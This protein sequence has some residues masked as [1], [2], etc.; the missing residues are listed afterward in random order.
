MRVQASSASMGG[1][2]QN[3]IFRYKPR[4]PAATVLYQ[5][6]QEH[7]ATFLALLDQ[8]SSVKN[9]PGYVRDEFMAFLRCGILAHGFVRYRCRACHKDLLLAFSCK[10]R[11]FCPSCLARRMAET[12]ARLVT[13]ILPKQPYRQWVL[14]LPIPL[15]YWCASSPK[16][17]EFVCQAASAAIGAYYQA[18][19]LACG[20]LAEHTHPGL[21]VFVQR[22]GSALNLNVHLH[23][24]ALDGVYVATTKHAPPR[25]ISV[26]APSHKDLQKT[27][28]GLV[29]TV[30]TQLCAWGY[31]VRD[32]DQQFLLTG[33]D[34]LFA[35]EPWQAQALA[36]AVQGRIAFG[37]RA[38]EKIREL[39]GAQRAAVT[40]ACARFEGKPGCAAAQNFSLH[41]AVVVGAHQR[42]ALE[43]LL[44]YM[45][46]GPLANK[47]LT[48]LANGQLRYELKT[49]RANGAVA[50]CL[51]PLELLEKLAALVPLPKMHLIRYFGV[52]AAHHHLRAKVI[53]QPASETGIAASSEEDPTNTEGAAATWREKRRDLRQLW[54]DLLRRIFNLDLDQCPWC[55]AAELKFV[56]VI[57]DPTVIAKILQTLGKSARAP[58]LAPARN[59]Q[60]SFAW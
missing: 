40:P 50:I 55:G 4:D 26:A 19:A 57:R 47:R 32:S 45:A 54:K 20:Y 11:G 5:T 59:V 36:A 37:P 21:V 53:L 38:G 10:R 41:A 56:A 13:E 14:S 28:N 27:L 15:R 33:L 2:P 44:R 24:L 8:D 17:T 58:P 49:P 48:L 29:V 7:L 1:H 30:I 3:T 6:I 51:S 34:P 31:L 25:F 46:R 22:F 52:F 9:L 43:R 23:V 16:L 39:H 35:D 12:A 18:K 60:E 42:Q